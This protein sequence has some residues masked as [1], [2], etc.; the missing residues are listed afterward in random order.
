[1]HRRGVLLKL[2]LGEK[3]EHL[4]LSCKARSALLKQC[5]SDSFSKGIH[6]VSRLCGKDDLSAQVEV[7]KAY[8]HAGDT[9][10]ML[11]T[12]Y[13]STRQQESVP[14]DLWFTVV[15]HLVRAGWSVEATDLIGYSSTKAPH[16]ADGLSK[17]T[18]GMDGYPGLPS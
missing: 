10:R 12:F 13:F 14:D 7:V 8:D 16:L 4:G 18:R 11:E 9:A 6:L 1:M 5:E 2:A 15:R 3:A 17:Q